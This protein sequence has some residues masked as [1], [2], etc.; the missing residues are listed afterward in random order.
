MCNDLQ[1]NKTGKLDD[2]EKAILP[3]IGADELTAQLQIMMRDEFNAEI[4]LEK[5]NSIRME[6]ENGEQ[7]E[8]R[9]I[10]L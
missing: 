6:F 9:V 3:S 1:R 5:N 4:A 8:I 2:R 7:F 10:K